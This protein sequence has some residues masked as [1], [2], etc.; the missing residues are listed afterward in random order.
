MAPG[1]LR[2]V[3]SYPV[4]VTV[5]GSPVRGDRIALRPGSRAVRATA[6]TVFFSGSRTIEAASG[7]TYDWRLPEAVPVTVAATPG[8][9]RIRIDG[10]DVGYVPAAVSLTVGLHEFEFVWS[11]LDQSLTV[12]EEISPSTRRVFRAAPRR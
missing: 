7:E 8:N 6:P 9:C 10:R 1:T 12:T 11:A 5:D 2:V 3:A 4:K